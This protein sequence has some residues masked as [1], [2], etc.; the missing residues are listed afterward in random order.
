MYSAASDDDEGLKAKLIRY[1]WIERW[2]PSGGRVVGV[3]GGQEGACEVQGH[4][5]HGGPEGGGHES[6]GT[7]QQEDNH[8]AVSEFEGVP[9][10]HT[11]HFCSA[12]AGGAL[13]SV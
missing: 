4:F 7:G 13:N 10:G 6:D 12:C 3:V 1:A 11:R 2:R 5:V 8:S 9:R